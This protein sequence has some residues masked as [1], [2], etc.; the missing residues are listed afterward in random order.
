M[1]HYTTIRANLKTITQN[2]AD[3]NFHDACETAH[4]T[5]NEVDQKLK[6]GVLKSWYDPM[7]NKASL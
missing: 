3:K 2:I 5:L 1:S 7:G 6:S 4:L